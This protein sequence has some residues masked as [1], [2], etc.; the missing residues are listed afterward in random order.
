MTYR[1]TTYGY[2]GMSIPH[3][4]GYTYQEARERVKRR[5]AYLAKEG[6]TVERL[7]P[8]R[9][10]ALEPEDCM[11]VPDY[12]GIIEIERESATHWPPVARRVK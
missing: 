5:I 10:E 3:G 1:V 2:C 12:C 11:M 4:D 6:V 7:S 8:N 9:F